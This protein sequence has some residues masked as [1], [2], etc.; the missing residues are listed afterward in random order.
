MDNTSGHKPPYSNKPGNSGM[1]VMN[2]FANPIIRLVLRSPLH[3]L[4]SGSLALITYR[5]R[6]SGKEYTIPVQ[7]V[8]GGEKVYIVPLPNAPCDCLGLPLNT[9]AEPR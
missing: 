6:K 4:F 5:G 1:W 8:Q 3:G 2:H 9:W 7:Y